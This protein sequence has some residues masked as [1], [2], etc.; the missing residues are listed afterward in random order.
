[1]N[2]IAPATQAGSVEN[3]LQPRR[4]SY[5]VVKQAAAAGSLTDAYATLAPR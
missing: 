3:V 5:G 1:M 2:A 4:G